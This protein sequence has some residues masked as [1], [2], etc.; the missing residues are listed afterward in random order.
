MHSILTLATKDIRLLWR[1]RAA[2]FW[3]L[4]WPLIFAFFFGSIFGSGGSGGG[5]MKIAVVDEDSTATSHQYVALLDSSSALRVERMNRDQAREEVRKGNRVAYVIVKAGFGDANP[6]FGGGELPIQIGIDPSRQAEI[7]YLQGLLIEASF[8]IQ[9]EKLNDSVAMREQVQ[10]AIVGLDLSS[11][12]P[13]GQKTALKD[14]LT[15]LDEYYAT[16]DTG[17]AEAGIQFGGTDI[18]VD[19]VVRDQIGR[20]RSAFEISFPSAI[21]WALIA[22]ATTFAVSMVLE[23][24][25]GTLLR[26]RTS[27]LSRAQ[28]M[29]GKALACFLTC[30]GIVVVLLTLAQIF[31]GVRVGDAGLLALGIFCAALCYTGLM[32]LFSVLGK[33]PRAVGG[34][35]WAIMLAMAMF[36]GGMIPLIAMPGWMQTAS[37]ASP[38]KWAILA[39][40]GGI[41]RD[42]TLADMMLPCLVLVGVGVVSFSIGVRVFS[43]TEG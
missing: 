15:S 26:L 14:L 37:N 3:V 25:E 23:R 8:K 2:L 41:W 30:A 36:G 38:V 24:Q 31:F 17:G 6:M 33:T 11:N 39:L 22:C 10:G 21:L 1:D 5:G 32:M 28:I 16:A 18:E 12:L 4:V 27:P 7:G 13:P 40:E 29:A 19:E 42:F 43:W 9:Q 20:P 35:S 34:V